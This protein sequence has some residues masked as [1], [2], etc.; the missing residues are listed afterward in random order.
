MFSRNASST[1]A[2]PTERQLKAIIDDPVYPLI[3]TSNQKGMQGGAELPPETIE[4]IKKEWDAAREDAI[5][6]SRRLA[7]L[8][9]HKQYAGRITEPFAHISVICT[10]TNF[11]NFFALRR[12]PDAFPEIHELADKM[13]EAMENSIPQKLEKGQWH[14]PFVDGIFEATVRNSSK[15]WQNLQISLNH[16]VAC[17]ARVSY[18]NHDG[19]SSTPEQDKELF[20]RLTGRFPKHSS[21][22]EH[23]AMV[24]N[25]GKY[26]KGNFSGG[27]FQYRKMFS[28]ECVYK[29]SPEITNE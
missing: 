23:Q 6:H 19:T 2:I 24:A 8:G 29:N 28:D 15:D 17:C 13:Y 4:E 1:R 7:E 14:L 21:P 18:K 5:K 3:Y 25:S 12:H 9:L 27:W 26:N 10:A 11:D 20:D 22:L 16:S